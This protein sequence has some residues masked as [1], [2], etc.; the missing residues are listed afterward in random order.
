VIS[1]YS[2]QL[3]TESLAAYQL[4]NLKRWANFLFWRKLEV[5]DEN[6][7]KVSIA[8]LV[9]LFYGI[10]PFLTVWTCA[11]YKYYFELMG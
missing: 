8:H 11:N 4:L 1:F 2:S 3:I 9:E 5:L 10:A 6:Y 7:E